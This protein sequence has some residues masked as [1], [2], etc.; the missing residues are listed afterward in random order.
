MALPCIQYPR[1]SSAT[2]QIQES[3]VTNGQFLPANRESN[4]KQ[5]NAMKGC[6]VEIKDKKNLEDN[7][8]NKCNAQTSL[9]DFLKYFEISN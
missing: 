2:S 8:Q 4:L 1:I 5:T 3:V 7:Y 6:R 9:L